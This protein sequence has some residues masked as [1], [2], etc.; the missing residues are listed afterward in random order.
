VRH[1]ALVFTKIHFIVHEAFDQS[2]PLGALCGLFTEAIKLPIMTRLSFV[3]SST[4]V[5]CSMPLKSNQH[6]PA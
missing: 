5:A 1:L 6:H 3:F 4:G 2:Q